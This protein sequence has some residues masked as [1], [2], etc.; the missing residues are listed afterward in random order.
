MLRFALLLTVQLTGAIDISDLHAAYGQ[1]FP[2]QNR[3]AASHLWSSWVIQRASSLGRDD[4]VNLFSGFCPVSGSPVNPE[5]RNTYRYS[6]PHLG[7][8]EPAVGLI[9]HCCTPCVCD[10]HDLVKTDSKRVELADGVVTFNFTVIGDPCA[11]PGAL[12]SPFT[13]PFSGEVTSLGAS[14]PEVHCGADGRLRGATYSDHGAVIIGLLAPMPSSALTSGSDDAA[15][16][17]TQAFVSECARRASAGY[18][19]GMGLI[20]RKVASI[21]ALPPPTTS[22]LPATAPLVAQPSASQPS[23]A[24]SSEC[25]SL[26]LA[27]RREAIHA[28]IRSQPVVLIG[29]RHMRCTNAASERLEAAGACFQLESWDEPTEPLW[30]YMKCLHP[31]ELVGG[32]EMHSYVYVGGEY[33]GN[34]FALRPDEMSEA[35]LT[36]K[37]RAADA[38]MTCS[39]DC[40]RLAPEPER[41]QLD[42]MVKQPLALLGWSGCPCTNIARSR[43]ESVGACYVQQVWPT[44]TAPLY[45]HL[46]CKYGAHHHS[47]VFV[48]GKFVGDGFAL[49]TDRLEQP[50]FEGM[51]HGAGAQLMCQH[52]GD[53]GLSGRP[54][55]SCTQS[56]DGSTTGWARTGSCNWD[57]SDSELACVSTPPPPLHTDWTVSPRAFQPRTSYPVHPSLP[58]NL[59]PSYPP[60]SYLLLP[61]TLIPT[62]LPT[63]PPSP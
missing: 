51:V 61:P 24:P 1:I 52:E 37:L 32:M 59:L 41:E 50:T 22:S 8:A 60:T 33:V 10:T 6:L 23:A 29:M 2:T 26:L 56:T 13:D 17:D 55:Q 43:F 35:S 46:Q 49:G 53:L 3:N 19:S 36:A 16:V 30:A 25:A 31:G 5:P 62:L 44:D 18:N 38:Q 45:K 47:F 54:L 57:P 12:A 39:R 15:F 20:F 48:G 28:M 58:S 7:S 14:A 42:A 34:G 4:F 40:D 11:N 9:H 63:L 27:E 21:T